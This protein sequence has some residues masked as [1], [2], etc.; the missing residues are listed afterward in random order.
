MGLPDEED[1]VAELGMNN[2]TLVVDTDAHYYEN[3]RAFGR[4]LAGPWRT[5]LEQWT[6][7]YFAPVAAASRTHDFLLGGRLKRTELG[8]PVT[9]S[10][11]GVLEIMEYLGIDITV[12]LP[13]MLLGI[14]EITDKR[15]ALALCQGFIEHM[16]NEVVD[17]ERG[18]YTLIVAANQSPTE[19]ATM[20]DSYA[21]H[22]GVCGVVMMTDAPN[23][24]FGDSYYDPIYEACVRNDVALV[25]HSGYGGPEGQESGY[26]LQTYVENHLAFVL[27][28][29]RQLTSMIFQGVPE[30]F[31]E[32]RLIF[33]E[34][35]IFWIPQ[36]MFRLDS[37]YSMRRAEVPWLKKTPSEYIKKMYFGTQPLERVPHEKYLKYVFEMIDGER[38]LTFAT[39]W[40]HTDF[41]A[42]LTIQRMSFLSA[43][44]K[45][46]ILG[47]N[48]RGVLRFRRKGRV[49]HS[50]AVLPATTHA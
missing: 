48:A 36:M 8:L 25:L 18:I 27:N 50:H 5:R 11:S 19:A 2:P 45:A 46:N 12:L 14:A 38:T 16:L 42:P 17:P 21:Q 30:R 37:E 28:N 13:G 9:D 40:P 6:G 1:P 47:N 22:D 20:I 23:L 3:P 10:R 49:E 32:L 41:D 15:R 7:S 35:G 33:Q 39:D 4:Y 31:P 44:G 34:A 43:E 29:M 24:P 26:G